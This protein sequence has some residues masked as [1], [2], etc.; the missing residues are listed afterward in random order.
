MKIRTKTK[1]WWQGL[2]THCW[3]TYFALVRDGVG[4]WEHIPHS[5]Q[6]I[7]ALCN[8]LF[9]KKFVQS[10]QDILRMYFTT[11]WGDD[12]YAV[13]DYAKRKGIPDSVIWIVVNR[14]SRMIVEEIGLLEKK[15]GDNDE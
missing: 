1:P 2:A 5:K 12:R 14:A 3:R 9:V 4:D 8:H 6:T 10:D 15:D 7:Y 13:E 11:H